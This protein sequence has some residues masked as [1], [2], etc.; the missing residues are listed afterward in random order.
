MKSVNKTKKEYIHPKTDDRR[1]TTDNRR[2]ITEMRWSTLIKV[3]TLDNRTIVVNCDLIERLEEVP[4]T[5]VTLES[6]K[7][8]MVKESMDEI[9]E[10]IIQYRIKC[11][12][13]LPERA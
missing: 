6:G 4:E 11:Q 5:V 10:L 1:L 12:G 8:F 9:I 13:S 3:T 7:K 2:L